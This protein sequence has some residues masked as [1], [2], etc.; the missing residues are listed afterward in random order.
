MATH[1]FE[2]RPAL[3]RCVEHEHVD[4]NYACTHLLVTD[5]N[6]SGRTRILDGE[7][8]RE[9]ALALAKHA[10]TLHRKAEG[11]DGGDAETRTRFATK[12]ARTRQLAKDLALDDFAGVMCG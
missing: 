12:L 1:S 8:L 7:D 10:A 11:W 3:D 9:L 2:A 4:A 6:E 5:V